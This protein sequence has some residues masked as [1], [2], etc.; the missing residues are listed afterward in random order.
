MLGVG[1]G[2]GHV[3]RLEDGEGYLGDRG[4]RIEGGHVL[5]ELDGEKFAHATI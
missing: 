3:D 2:V 5:E 1:P 4:S